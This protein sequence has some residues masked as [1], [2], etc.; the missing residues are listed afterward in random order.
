MIDALVAA[1][2][3]DIA[4]I[5]RPLNAVVTP[6][7]PASNAYYQFWTLTPRAAGLTKSEARLPLAGGPRMIIVNVDTAVRCVARTDAWARYGRPT[8]LTPASPHAP[9]GSPNYDV[10]HRPWGDLRLGINPAGCVTAVVI[11]AAG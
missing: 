10:Y 8:S 6:G 2:G 1:R 11:D 5:S 4:A 9:A 3:G 7:D